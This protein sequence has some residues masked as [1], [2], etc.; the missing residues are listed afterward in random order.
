MNLSLRM[1]YLPAIYITFLGC[2]VLI[3]DCNVV[4]I[5]DGKFNSNLIKYKCLLRRNK[6]CRF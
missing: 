1:H 4:S 6:Q 5:P 3:A 2:I